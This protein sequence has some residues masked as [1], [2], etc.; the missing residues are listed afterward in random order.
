MEL[1]L[2]SIWEGLFAW[3]CPGLRARVYQTMV[4]RAGGPYVGLNVGVV[5]S[6]S[7]F[8]DTGS[9]DVVETGS[10]IVNKT[11]FIGGGQVGYNWQDQEFVYGV[12]ADISGLAANITTQWHDSQFNLRQTTHKIDW[13]S[14]LR[15]RAGLAIGRTLVYATGGLALAGVKDSASQTASDGDTVLIQKDDTRVG[16]TIGGGLEHMFA[17]NWTARIEGLYVDLGTSGQL[18]PSVNTICSVC[19]YSGKFS[20]SLVIGRVGV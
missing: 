12:E 3:T 5:R 17:P 13:L 10:N 9:I 11:G 1:I 2:L 18:N 4:S 8:Q 15:V 19:V 16:W 20:H 6:D 14:T 7:N